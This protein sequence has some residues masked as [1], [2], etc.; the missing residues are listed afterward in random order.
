[1]VVNNKLIQKSKPH[2][3]FKITV[4]GGKKNEIIINIISEQ[5]NPLPIF[6]YFIKLIKIF[7]FF[8]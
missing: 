4:M 8:L 1:M 5:D 2:P 6:Y 7:I 3:L